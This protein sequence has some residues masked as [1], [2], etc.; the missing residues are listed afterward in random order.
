MH[1]ICE[2]LASNS[3]LHPLF[4]DAYKWLCPKRSKHPPSSD[5]WHFR[6]NWNK[7]KEVVIDDSAR[8][9]YSLSVQKKI[10]LSTGEI[11]ALWSSGVMHWS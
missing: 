3:T 4:A 5:V 7:I 2:K 6:R 8:G 9:R 10:R 1:S 11:I